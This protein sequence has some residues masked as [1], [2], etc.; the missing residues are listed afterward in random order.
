MK[1]IA[2]S[3]STKTVWRIIQEGNI[4]KEFVTEGINPYYQTKEQIKESFQKDVLINCDDFEVE[5]IFFYGAGCTEEKKYIIEESLREFFPTANK[6]EVH[7]DLLATARAMCQKQSGIVAILGTGS[8][9]AL[10]QEGKIVQNTSAL[11]YILGDEGSGAVL[12]RNLINLLFKNQLPES[13]KEKF[14]KEYQTNL[15]EIIENVYRKN[16]PNRYL[17]SFTPFIKKHIDNK[18]L[19]QMVEKSFDDFLKKNILQYPKSEEL[20]IHF[21]GS[22]AFYFQDILEK[23]VKKN[24]MKMGKVDQTPMEGLTYYHK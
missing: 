23:T 12:G 5:E 21:V 8:N 17:A 1:L 4:E 3:G 20:P 15:S 13:L 9:S 14:L 6:V 19:Y 22:V 11:G 16:F 2:D 10:Y 24:N 7:S 18:E